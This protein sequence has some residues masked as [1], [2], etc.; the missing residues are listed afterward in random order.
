ML[1]RGNHWLAREVHTLYNALMSEEDG[2][3]LWRRCYHAHVER[4]SFRRFTQRGGG[5]APR[6]LESLHRC[7]KDIVAVNRVSFVDKVGG[8]A[9]AHGPEADKTNGWFRHIQFQ[10][11]ALAS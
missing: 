1:A 11:C 8:H 10:L 4:L 9:E 3:R 7:W 5:C 2:L 6:S